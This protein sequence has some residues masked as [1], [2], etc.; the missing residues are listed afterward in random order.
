MALPP[1]VELSPAETRSALLFR[2]LGLLQA[3]AAAHGP[4]FT[5][6]LGN[7]AP[8]VVTANLDD[9]R[10]IFAAPEAALSSG[11]TAQALLPFLGDQ[12]VL[13]LEGADHLATRRLLGAV[14]QRPRP[15]VAPL[16]D[17]EVDGWTVGDA[18]RLD[19][20]MARIA[21]GFTVRWLVGQPD[22]DLAAAARELLRHTSPALQARDRAWPALG[23]ALASLRER[24]AGATPGPT[25]L[26][27]GLRGAEPAA[28]WAIDQA[29]A[30]IIAGHETTA[31]TLAWA[32]RY[33]GPNPPPD[34]QAFCW[35]VLRLH[36]VV[37]F[38]QRRALSAWRLGPWEL[39]P[40]TLMAPAIALVHRDPRLYDAPE[41][42]RPERYAGQ[43]PTAPAWAPF[44]GGARQCLGLHTA[45]H[46][47][48]QVLS[49]LAAQ[50]T[51]APWVGADPR[52]VRRNLTVAPAGGVRRVV[53][54]LGAP[55]ELT[56]LGLP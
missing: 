37:P 50:V 44:G 19:Q 3:G 15:A 12:A 18:V 2:P 31:T 33:L 11:D 4:R 39:P 47:V 34:P 14:L 42:F 22:P 7:D 51:L 26:L 6:D 29:V 46:V 41:A 1:V 10:G 52:P 55:P 32:A 20:V 48:P 36:P 24:L 35:E 25:S 45:L 49:R 27:A 30:L 23:A 13:A 17:A 28:G 40:G 16:V 8:L 38:V 56:D 21:L 53:Q 54:A 43:R 5:L 9:V